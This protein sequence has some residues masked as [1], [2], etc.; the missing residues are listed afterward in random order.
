MLNSVMLFR[1]L[2]VVKSVGRTNEITR[3]SSYSLERHRLKRICHFNI[4]VVTNFKIQ[5]VKRIAGIVRVQ[6]VVT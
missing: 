2:S 4:V 1:T 6:I 3:N 5:T